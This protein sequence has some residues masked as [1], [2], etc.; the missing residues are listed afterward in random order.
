MRA[1][2]CETLVEQP[3]TS[4][5]QL[6]TTE[7][8]QNYIQFRSVSNARKDRRFG[9]APAAAVMSVMA[10]VSGEVTPW[11][12]GI[13]VIMCS[14]RQDLVP[15]IQGRRRREASKTYVQAVSNNVLPSL[16]NVSKVSSTPCTVSKSVVS[17]LR[18]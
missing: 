18:A 7:Y 17:D 12:K 6:R 9:R 10:R 5:N 13:S 14:F 11:T 3:R 16:Y 2:R 4:E 15:R 8:A 1:W